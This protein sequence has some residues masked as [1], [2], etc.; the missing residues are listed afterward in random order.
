MTHPIALA[1]LPCAL[2]IIAITTLD[3]RDWIATRDVIGI[4]QGVTWL[5]AGLAVAALSTS[6]L[7]PDLGAR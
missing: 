3:L 5:L 6:A 1:L 4:A 7:L 2:T